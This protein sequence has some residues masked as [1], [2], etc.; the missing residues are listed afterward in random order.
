[1]KCIKNSFFSMIEISCLLFT[2][3]T[4]LLTDLLALGQGA[5]HPLPWYPPICTNLAEIEDG[6]RSY[7]HYDVIKDRSAQTNQRPDER[8]TSVLREMV[9]QKDMT[10]EEIGQRIL[11]VL[12]KVSWARFSNLLHLIVHCGKKSV[13]WDSNLD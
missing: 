6:D 5:E 2:S 12:K 1:M 4:A 9:G 3:V 13:N 11:S 10:I 8:M 7:D